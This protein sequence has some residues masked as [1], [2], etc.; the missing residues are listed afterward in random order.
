MPRAVLDIVREYR[1]EMDVISSFVG[2]ECDERGA[3]AAKT[4][5]AAYC[6]W[7]ERNNEYCMSNTKFGAELAKRYKKVRTNK[8]VYYNGISLVS[9]LE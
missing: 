7:A 3:A 4:L 5:Y 8:G 2:D 1:R 9:D 6:K